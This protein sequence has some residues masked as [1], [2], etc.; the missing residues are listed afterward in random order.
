MNEWRDLGPAD[1]L[2]DPPLR[3]LTIERTTVALSYIDGRFGAISNVCN[4]VGGPLGRGRL[5]GDYVTCPWHNWKFHRLTGFGEPGFEDDRVPQYELKVEA[6]R[7]YIKAQP[8]TQRN[9][10]P[11]APHALARPV[12]R[13][14]GPIR[15]VGISTT[16][17]DPKNPRYSTSDKLLEIAIDHARTALG[18]QT[19]LIK[20]ND[21]KF[22]NCEG[23]YSKAARACTWPCSITQMDKADELDKVYE[24]LVHWGDVVMVATPIRWGAASSLYHKMAERMN[25]IQNQITI[26]DRVLIQNK[27]ASFIITGGQDNVQDVA[28][29]MLGFFAE[30]GFF[31]PPFPYIAHSR[32]WSA[33]DMEN[34]MSFVETSSDLQEGA[35]DLARRSVEMAELVLGKKVSTE[36]IVHPGRKAQPLHLKE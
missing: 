9:K 18:A 11:H 15:V 26:A 35:K 16:A 20:L 6:G 7:L 12:K 28:G 1:S 34:N 5:D 22:R 29:H 31:F 33:E 8:A 19:L 24:A 2:K 23:Y 17:M 32:G 36:R 25:C 27:V 3:E 13:E 10:R 30:L 21:L 4:H 14:E